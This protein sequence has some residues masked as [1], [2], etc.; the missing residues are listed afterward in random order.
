MA[1]RQGIYRDESIGCGGTVLDSG[2]RGLRFRTLTVMRLPRHWR[3]LFIGEFMPV[4]TTVR[5]YFA[6]YLQF[7]T[8]LLLD[9][10]A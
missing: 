7:P 6:C 8:G 10:G 1:A 5:L 3:F 9:P 4:P 2:K